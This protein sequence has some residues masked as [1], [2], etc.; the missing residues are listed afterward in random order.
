MGEVDFFGQI[1][2]HDKVVRYEID[3][4]RY[5]AMESKGASMVVGNATVSV[6]GSEIYR[7]ENARVGTFTGIRYSDYPLPGEHSRGG[8]N[9]S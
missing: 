1:R 8:R 5:T 7:I 6:D 3:I 2:P 9:E 4:R